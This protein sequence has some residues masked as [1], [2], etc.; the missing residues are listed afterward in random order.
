MPEPA[1]PLTEALAAFVA[2]LD[3]RGL[4]DEVRRRALTLVLDGSGALLA[5][6][7]P[8]YSTGRLIAGLARDLGG[9]EGTSSVVG[10]GAGVIVGGMRE[11]V[12]A[13]IVSTSASSWSSNFSILGL[14]S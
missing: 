7:N 9:G 6:S 14:N 8:D 1:A 3:Q 11:W 2:G 4:P 12:S 5:A 10:H 13:T